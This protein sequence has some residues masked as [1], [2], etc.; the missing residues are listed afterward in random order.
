MLQNGSPFPPLAAKD[1]EG[2]EVVVADLLEGAWS[3]VLFY[4]GHW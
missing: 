1:L 3:A 4:R 2:S